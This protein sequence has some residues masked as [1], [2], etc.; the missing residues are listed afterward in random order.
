LAQGNIKSLAEWA[1][2]I[3]FACIYISGTDDRNA[4]QVNEQN[5]KK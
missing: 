1:I 3:P 5:L 2:E 4:T